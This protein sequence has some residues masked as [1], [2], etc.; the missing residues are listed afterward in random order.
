L[1]K[2]RRDFLCA[3]GAAGTGVALRTLVGSAQANTPKPN[4]GIIKASLGDAIL[5]P[6]SVGDTWSAA[7]ADDDE[8]YAS[9]D[10]TT[11]FNGACQSNLAISR[12]T[13]DAPAAL[14]GATVNCMKEF[15]GESE[16]RRE[17]GGM[18]KACRLTCVD[19]VLYMAVSRHLV[20]PTE[21][22]PVP[23]GYWEGRYSPFWIQEAWDASIIK[24]SD[25]GKTWSAGPRLGHAM[26]P[27]RGFSTPF[28]VQYGKDGRGTK[29]DADQFVYAVSND[30]AWNNGNWMVL[31]RVPRNRIARLD[32]SD[33]EFVH[34]YDDKRQP[35]WQ[36]RWDNALYIF[37][38][39]GRASMTG[40]HYLQGLDLYVMPQWHYPFLE[41]PSRRFR[42]T[43]LELYQAP[44]PWGPW[45]LF[46]QQ[47]FDPQS[48]YNPCIPSKFISA[49]GRRFYLFLAGDFLGAGKPVRYYGLWMIPVT[50]EV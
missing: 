47:D 49:D 20:C 38:A 17:D 33:W 35:I 31:G 16:I 3:V 50:L 39:P 18:W 45:T 12:L 2:T 13:G 4:S 1:T 8:L 23:T 28:F 10:D 48:W 6:D 41:D 9:S 26:F 34:G 27:G 14:R 42:C 40:I 30:G 11:G 25:H 29:D 46:H 15:G 19:G 24:S 32:A 22:A 5:V 44:A 43:R 36:P 21:P 37:R 7:W